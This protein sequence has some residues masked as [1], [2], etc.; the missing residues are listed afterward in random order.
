MRCWTDRIK[1]TQKPV[2]RQ[3]WNLQRGGDK[4]IYQV[5]TKYIRG[6]HPLRCHKILPCSI[7]G[8]ILQRPWM[9][10]SVLGLKQGK[11][12]P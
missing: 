12:K 5:A 7:W 8:P 9:A 6:D 1:S 2:V 4:V 11:G 10:D 3:H